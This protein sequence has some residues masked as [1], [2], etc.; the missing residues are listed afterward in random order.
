VPVSIFPFCP[1]CP[2]WSRWSRKVTT[3]SYWSKPPTRRIRASTRVSPPTRPVKW[4]RLRTWPCTVSPKTKQNKQTNTPKNLR[5]KILHDTHKRTHSLVEIKI[6]IIICRPVRS[7]E[8]TGAEL[9]IYIS[10][11][12]F[13]HCWTK[14]CHKI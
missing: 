14:L 7:V 8:T 13:L 2:S 9:Y 3:R 5:K 12:S 4:S 1:S 6:I 10:S 11:V